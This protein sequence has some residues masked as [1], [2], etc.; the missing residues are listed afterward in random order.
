MKKS[1]QTRSAKK[2]AAPKKSAVIQ[3]MRAAQAK[4]R[5]KGSAFNPRTALG[6]TSGY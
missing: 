1:R 5:S 4:G 3:K 6:A 2:P